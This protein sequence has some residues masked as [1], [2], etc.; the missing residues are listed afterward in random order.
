[1]SLNGQ[2]SLFAVGR[3]AGWWRRRLW[4]RKGRLLGRNLAIRLDE[5]NRYFQNFSNEV[6]SVN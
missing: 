2:P 1:M 3:L 4:W 6:A 5:S